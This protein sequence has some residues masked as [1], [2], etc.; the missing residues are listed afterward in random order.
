MAFN[1]TLMRVIVWMVASVFLLILLVTA[2][3]ARLSNIWRAKLPRVVWGPTPIISIKFWSDALRH[4]GYQSKTLVYTI[5]PAY[6]REDFDITIDDFRPRHRSLQFLRPYLVMV[7]CLMKFDLFVFFFDGGFLAQTP[8]ASFECQILK[9]AGKKLILTSYG[10]DIAVPEYLSFFREP[11]LAHYPSLLER[12]PAIKQRVLYFTRYADL[13][14]KNLQVGFL[15]KYDF[16]WPSYLAIDVDLWK[17]NGQASSADG[18]TGEIVVAHSSNHRL[19][20][21]TDDLIRAVRELQQEGLKVRLAL[22]EQCSNAEVRG[23]ITN[24]DIFAE[25]FIGGYAMAA[26][27]GMSLG[28]PVL[29]NLSCHDE[30]LR[31]SPML[32][33]CPIVDTSVETIKTNLR[34]LITDPELRR[35]LGA[36][37][38]GFVLKYHSYKA[39]GAIWDFLIRSVWNNKPLNVHQIL[40][41]ND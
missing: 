1:R 38:R 14:I 22:L 11:I 25:Q 8:L 16:F 4:L 34:L 3:I 35:T 23:S 26:I 21:G 37:S 31:N 20:K 2:G 5:Y 36:K 15:P 39:V 32:Q 7:W 40:A 30:E 28:K 19:I 29:S 24:C 6:S 33:E 12:G 41:M 17:P 9:L 18:Q 10:S 13:V 27:E